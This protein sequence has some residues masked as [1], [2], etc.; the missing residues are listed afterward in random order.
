MQKNHVKNDSAQT[1]EKS[2]KETL[3]SILETTKSHSI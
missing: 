1:S 3:E 2:L